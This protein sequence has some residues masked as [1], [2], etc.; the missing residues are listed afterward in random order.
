MPENRIRP[1]PEPLPEPANAS[2]IAIQT[3][4]L[5][6]TFGAFTALDHLDLV[7]PAGKISGLLGP[8]GAGKS[9]T[10][11]M[12]TTL[13]EPSSGTATVAGFDLVREPAKVRANIGYVPQMVSADG[14]LT[15]ME[16]LLLSARLY[17]IPRP[18]R[19]DR[20]QEALRFMDL[21]EAGGNLVRTY[22]GGMVRRLELAQAMLHQPSV[23]FLDEP[24][25]G[26]DPTARHLVWDH[27]REL[28]GRL[29]LTVLITTHDMEE[30]ND[31]CDELTFLHQG[32]SAGFGAPAALKAALGPDADLDDVFR[33]FSGATAEEGGN[34]RDVRQ[35]RADAQRHS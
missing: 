30:A 29:Q 27:L 23:L 17:G 25:I 26:L 3:F 2:P 19:A 12:L 4:A 21:A 8:N 35:A 20:I 32:R 22:S 13:L 10:I 15:G 34:L 9:T 14:A 5:T 33:K 16:N 7:V 11:K 24:T 1:A 31:L 28:K 18:E 6:R